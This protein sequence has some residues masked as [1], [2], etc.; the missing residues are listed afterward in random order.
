MSSVLIDSHF[1]TMKKLRVSLLDACNFRCI[2]CMPED[3]KFSNRNNYLPYEELVKI[4]ENLV[5]LG[6]DEVRLTGGEPTLSPDFMNTVR[7][8]NH[9]K[10]S[11]LG[12]T[13]NGLTFK[14]HVSELANTQLKH[15]NFSLDTLDNKKF[16]KITKVDG[17]KNVIESIHLAQSY[18]MKVKVNC[19]VMKN[20]NDDEIIDFVNFSQ[21]RGVEVR[22]LE[23]MNIG[24]VKPH[25]DRWFISAKEMID[26][27]E[28][29]HSLTR[30]QDSIDSTSMN[31]NISNGA[32]VGFIASESEPFCGGCSRLRLDAKG[33]LYPC[34]FK[35]E[36]TDL[37]DVPLDEYGNLLPG[38]ISKKPITRIKVQDKPMH[39]LGG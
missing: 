23:T 3:A 17:L 13:T 19:V 36:G 20:V 30:K 5:V 16:K 4:V 12:L 39:Q 2:Y 1:R 28:L 27:I 9:L 29:H 11:K 21:R 14:K 33:V 8:L 31:Y 38:L 35:S 24:V 7:G 15:V 26:K 18:G 22:F 6:I 32:Q 37:K 10:L 34:L 25:F